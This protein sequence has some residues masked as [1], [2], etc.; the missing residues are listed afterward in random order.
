MSHK[1]DLET[2]YAAFSRQV[3]VSQSEIA[4]RSAED[5]DPLASRSAAA[6]RLPDT[7]PAVAWEH[8]GGW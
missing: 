6:D 5:D 8:A 4:R 7:P 3:E 2:L 1:L